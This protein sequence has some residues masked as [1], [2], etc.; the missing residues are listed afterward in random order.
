MH[1]NNQVYVDFLV[2]P[3][4]CPTSL[5]G[6]SLLSTLQ[7]TTSFDLCSLFVLSHVIHRYMQSM[8]AAYAFNNKRQRMSRQATVT[9]NI[10]SKCTTNTDPR[11]EKETPMRHTVSSLT[12]TLL[13]KHQSE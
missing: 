3:V 8:V 6:R 1:S 5:R 9:R 10:S 2:W 13:S 11:M 12:A 4:S 7:S